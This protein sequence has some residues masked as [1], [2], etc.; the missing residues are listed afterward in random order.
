MSNMVK[1]Y[2]LWM[3]YTFIERDYIDDNVHALSEFF[4][5]SR[6]IYQII[7]AWI[8]VLFKRVND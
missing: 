5:K 1:N 7:A 2:Y 8:K 4:F 6:T 3:N